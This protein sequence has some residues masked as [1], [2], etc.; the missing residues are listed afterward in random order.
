MG[1]HL[2][3][4]SMEF[5]IAKSD[6]LAFG[7]AENHQKNHIYFYSHEINGIEYKKFELLEQLLKGSDDIQDFLVTERMKKRMKKRM[8]NARFSNHG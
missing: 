7:S 3:K 6:F 1:I 8:R 2:V 4:Q 5:D